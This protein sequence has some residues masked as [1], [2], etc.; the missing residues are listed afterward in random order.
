[1]A[2][3]ERKNHM[4]ELFISEKEC[5]QRFDKYLFKVLDRAPAG[6]IYKMLRKK[7][8]VLNEKKASGKEILQEKDQVKIYFSDETFSKFSS[9][10]AFPDRARPREDRYR[11]SGGNEKTDGKKSRKSDGQALNIVYEDSDILV[12]SKP[13]GLLSQKASADDDSAND[14]IIAYLLESGQITPEELRTFHPS[15]CNRLDRNTSG[16]LIAGKTMRGLQ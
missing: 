3:K 10:A 4:K 9:A 8:I 12:I 13:V 16:L 6:F 7:N 5:G 14:R 11:F 1:M 2:E 15:I